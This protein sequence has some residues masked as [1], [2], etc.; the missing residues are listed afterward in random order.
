MGEKLTPQDAKH[1]DL[2]YTFLLN[3]G[4]ASYTRAVLHGKTPST[5]PDEPSQKRYKLF[6]QTEITDCNDPN[7]LDVLYT[8]LHDYE[9]LM[10]DY[11]DDDY[12]NADFDPSK[13]DG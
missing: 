7:K 12:S 9:E 3:P 8:A 1:R 10:A 2:F 4:L 11:T 6:V 5:P 13:P